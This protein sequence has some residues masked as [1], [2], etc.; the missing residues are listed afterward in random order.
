MPAFGSGSGIWVF[1]LGK[2][3]ETEVVVVLYDCC[4]VLGV[5]FMSWWCILCLGGVFYGAYM[6]H[7]AH[8]SL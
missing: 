6:Y 7:T 4:A 1:T 5:Y 2:P 3:Q 8:I